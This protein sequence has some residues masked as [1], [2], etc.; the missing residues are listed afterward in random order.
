AIYLAIVAVVSGIIEVRLIRAGGDINTHIGLIFLLM[1]TPAAASLIAR[2]AM[3]EGVRDV[4][5]RLGGRRAARALLIAWLLP[6]CV[7]AV[8]YGAAWATGLVHFAPPAINEATIGWS[9]PLRFIA[10]LGITMSAGTLFSCLSAA[11]E[12]IG[13]RGYMLTRLIAA[14]V[15]YPLFA[16]GVI[17]GAWHLPLIFTG[18]YASSSRPALSAALFMAD[19]IAIAVVIGILR[20]YSGSVW[21]AVLLHATWNAVIQGPFDRTFTGAGAELWVGESG[22]LVALTMI[23]VAVLVLRWWSAQPSPMPAADS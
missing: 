11:G 19:V 23:V 3:D 18:Q 15:P 2:L 10:F 7:G 13:W 14:R 17:W 4:S 20:L 16:S 5:F 6:V 1:W 8:A 12:E 21:P 22:V 9:R